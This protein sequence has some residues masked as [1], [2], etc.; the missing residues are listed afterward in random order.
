MVQFFVDFYTEK[1]VD[2]DHTEQ[3]RR[4]SSD[5]EAAI[6]LLE[7]TWS[8]AFVTGLGLEVKHKVLK[9]EKLTKLNRLLFILKEELTLS[10]KYQL[11]KDYIQKILP[12]E[13]HYSPISDLI[14]AMLTNSTS[15]LAKIP[16][17]YSTNHRSCLIANLYMIAFYGKNPA[18][19]RNLVAAEP[20]DFIETGKLMKFSLPNN[21]SID[22]KM[23]LQMLSYVTHDQWA[24]LP[25]R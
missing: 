10:Q 11:E 4:K 23:L 25:I 18:E 9:D 3:K 7:E 6:R 17:S 15:D 22:N 16:M 5:A 19:T 24:D 20:C 14:L 1:E 21:F 2:F 13:Y 8:T 12:P